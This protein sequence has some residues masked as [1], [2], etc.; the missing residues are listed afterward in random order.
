MSS[1]PVTRVLH[2]TTWKY[3]TSRLPDRFIRSPKVVKEAIM[4]DINDLVQEFWRT[5]S[6]GSVG[7]SFFAMRLLFENL[8]ECFVILEVSYDIISISRLPLTRT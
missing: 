2:T 5:S 1:I 7:A 4:A 8:E 3:F 6:D